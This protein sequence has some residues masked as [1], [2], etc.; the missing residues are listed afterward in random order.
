MN[1]QQKPIT[2]SI[3]LPFRP[4]AL[5]FSSPFAQE[6]RLAICSFDQ[7]PQNQFRIFRMV[8]PSI[9]AESGAPVKLPQTCCMF[10]P[11]GHLKDE[12]DLLL[13][14][15]DSLKLYT[16]APN[17]LTPTAEIQISQNNEPITGIDWSLIENSLVLTG[18]SDAT[19]SALNINTGQIMQQVIAH[20][21]PI[22][23]VK[24]CGAS[25]TFVTVGFDGS[26]RLFDLRDLNNS[27]ILYQTAKPLTRCAISPIDPNKIATF[28]R[29]SNSAIIIDSRKPGMAAS[30]NGD[31]HNE[32]VTCIGWSRILPGNFYSSDASGSIIL[33]KF[34][35]DSSSEMEAKEILKKEGPIESFS[36]G[37]G[38]LGVAFSDRVDIVN[39]VTQ[40]N[41]Q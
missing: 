33:T 5:S 19:V 29:G 39:G 28:S 3:P 21:H 12:T 31:Q 37:P 27:F 9:I 11:H 25:S 32:Q 14:G 17:S 1:E 26:L 23:D 8:G 36:I 16:T 24:F 40:M 30:A 35:D 20:D 4:F 6:N 38:V 2:L 22:H 41:A 18:S 13:L 7:N 15:G 10:S 34:V